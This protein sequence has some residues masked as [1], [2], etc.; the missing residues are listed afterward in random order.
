M[1]KSLSQ[2]EKL[3]CSTRFILRWLDRE[4]KCILI[5]EDKQPLL[6]YWIS[7][8][9]VRFGLNVGKWREISG[10]LLEWG[11]GAERRTLEEWWM[12]P[13]TVVLY[14]HFSMPSSPTLTEV[15]AF[16]VK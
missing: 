14:L 3:L 10:E 15:S 4:I 16:W 9:F 7:I 5:P 6:L 13:T 11:M 1:P 8:C 12:V 2:W